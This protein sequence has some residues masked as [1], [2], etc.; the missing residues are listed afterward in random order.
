MIILQKFKFLTSPSD[1][2]NAEIGQ[3]K[4]GYSAAISVTTDKYKFR[5]LGD[6]K[7]P[8][9]A[10]VA[11]VKECLVICSDSQQKLVSL[12]NDD[13]HTNYICVKTQRKILDELCPYVAI[14]P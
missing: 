9:L 11:M 14:D 8:E 3:T 12:Q 2:Y 6:F 7:S 4:S 13:T 10:F 5:E 1:Y